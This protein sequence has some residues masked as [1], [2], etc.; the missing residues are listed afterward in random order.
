[1]LKSRAKRKKARLC[2]AFQKQTVTDDNGQGT[3]AVENAMFCG[4]SAHSA[5]CA[6]KNP[7][8]MAGRKQ[9]P[10][11]YKSYKSYGSHF[12]ALTL[13]IAQSAPPASGNALCFLGK[14]MHMEHGGNLTFPP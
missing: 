9:N 11:P 1:M 6:V 10:S 13:C 14:A 5:P 8:H 4:S 3:F 2:A 12:F 7:K